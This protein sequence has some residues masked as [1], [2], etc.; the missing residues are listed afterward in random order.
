MALIGALPSHRVP[1][2]AP[3]LRVGHVAK[4]A[5]LLFPSCP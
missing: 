4:I 3:A 2:R 1:P 5:V